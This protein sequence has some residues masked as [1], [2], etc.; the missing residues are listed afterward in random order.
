M[1]YLWKILKSGETQMGLIANQAALQLLIQVKK[2]IKEACR[3][4][5]QEDR[6]SAKKGDG[7]EK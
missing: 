4:R 6:A 7:K 1:V 5:K 2:Q 3:K